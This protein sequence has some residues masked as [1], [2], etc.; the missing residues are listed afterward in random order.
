MLAA[1]NLDVQ[2]LKG[3]HEKPGVVVSMGP[4]VT[5]ANL[6]RYQCER[7]LRPNTQLRS[8][9]KTDSERLLGAPAVAAGDFHF[10]VCVE[11]GERQFAKSVFIDYREFEPDGTFQN[12]LTGYL[13]GVI[14]HWRV[15]LGDRRHLRE[16]MP[17]PVVGGRTQRVNRAILP[18][19]HSRLEILR[20]AIYRRDPPHLQG[21]E[22]IVVLWGHR[23]EHGGN[24]VL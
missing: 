2:T 4:V 5:W 7:Q 14:L 6:L 24:D 8:M 10:H 12:H 17:S 18:V 15:H 22:S 19:S 9:E 21:R 13:D 1:V 20:E 3:K 23:F 16:V 11:W